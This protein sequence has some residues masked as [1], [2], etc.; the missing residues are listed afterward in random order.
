MRQMRSLQDVIGNGEENDTD[1]E[2]NEI[3]DLRTTNILQAVSLLF[4]FNS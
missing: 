4:L 3:V 1:S 2:F